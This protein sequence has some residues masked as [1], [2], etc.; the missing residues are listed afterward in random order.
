MQCNECHCNSKLGYVSVLRRLLR[1]IY[2]DERSMIDLT[3][4][5]LARMNGDTMKGGNGMNKV[6]N[7][8]RN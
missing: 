2:E 6:N 5:D 7:L 1:V 3:K 4:V 8:L